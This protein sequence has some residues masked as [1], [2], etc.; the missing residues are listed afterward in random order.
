MIQLFEKGGLGLGKKKVFFLDPDE[1]KWTME[2]LGLSWETIGQSVHEKEIEG[3]FLA[4]QGR[5]HKGSELSNLCMVCLESLAYNDEHDSVFCPTCDE[6]REPSCADP[7][8]EYCLARPNR[9][10]QCN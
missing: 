8:C 10:S 3:I 5:I 7:D 4:Y 6:W 2:D 1:R 9:P